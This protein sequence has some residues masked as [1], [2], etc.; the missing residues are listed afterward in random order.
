MGCYENSPLYN[1]QIA[2]PEDRSNNPTQSQDLIL[3]SGSCLSAPD[4]LYFERMSKVDH[5]RAEGQNCES[6]SS[7]PLQQPIRQS[8]IVDLELRT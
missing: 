2:W 3:K 6:V 7:R 4:S 1:W 8:D 5:L